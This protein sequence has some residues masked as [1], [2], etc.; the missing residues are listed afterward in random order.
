MIH[1]FN[2]KRH[3]FNEKEQSDLGINNNAS[4]YVRGNNFFSLPG[5]F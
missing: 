1:I 2:I 3:V 4:E 5:N